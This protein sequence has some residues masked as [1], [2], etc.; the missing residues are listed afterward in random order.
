MAVKIHASV[1]PGTEVCVDVR[2]GGKYSTFR[3]ESPDEAVR[4]VRILNAAQACVRA[5]EAMH[6]NDAAPT[7]LKHLMIGDAIVDAYKALGLET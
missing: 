5:V 7:M 4:Y 6:A 2:M 3:A 1:A